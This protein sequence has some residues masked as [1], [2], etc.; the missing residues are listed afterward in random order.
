MT[1]RRRRQMTGFGDPR[2]EV[3]ASIYS[4]RRPEMARAMTSCCIS[5]VPS[6]IAWFKFPGFRGPSRSARLT[7]TRHEAMPDVGSWGL[8]H[9]F[10]G[11]R[12]GTPWSG[13]SGID[14]V[15]KAL[16]RASSDGESSKIGPRSGGTGR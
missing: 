16:V 6:K 13:S 12:L 1:S 2:D 8:V 10:L 11:C 14:Q 3:V 7:L 15:K 9:P 4:I 5:D